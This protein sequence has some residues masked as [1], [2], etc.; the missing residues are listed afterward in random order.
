MVPLYFQPMSAGTG[1]EATQ[2]YPEDFTLTKRPP[3]GTS[4]IARVRGDSM[5]PDYHNGDL[6]FV[7]ATVDIQPGQVGTFFMDGQMWIKELGDGELISRN[8]QYGP[9]PMTENVRCQGLVLGVCDKSYF[10]SKP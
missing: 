1:Q 10:E 2:E 8:P 5:E 6:V 7:H 9:R 3:R 4:Y